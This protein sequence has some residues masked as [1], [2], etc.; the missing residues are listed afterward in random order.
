[1]ELHLAPIIISTPLVGRGRMEGNH[2]Y[3]PVHIRSSFGHACS[4]AQP[5][6]WPLTVSVAGGKFDEG[7]LEIKSK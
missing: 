2:N 4:R 3:F 6:S 7:N 1:M 5:L